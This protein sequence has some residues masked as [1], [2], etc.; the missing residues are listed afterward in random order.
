MDFFLNLTN[1]YMRFLVYFDY[2]RNST[3]FSNWAT[4]VV[5]GTNVN[6]EN[7]TVN[8]CN[9]ERQHNWK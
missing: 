4:P 5:I 6:Q 8:F 2:K 3:A 7:N 9:L 1:V